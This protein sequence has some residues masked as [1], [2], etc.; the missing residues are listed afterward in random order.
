MN[1]PT[2]MIKCPIRLLC[3]LG[4]LVGRSAELGRLVGSLAVDSTKV[5]IETGWVPAYTTHQGLED[6][7]R[8]YLSANPVD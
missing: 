5:R 8:W 3:V 6:T 7:V 1:V 4:K 2:N